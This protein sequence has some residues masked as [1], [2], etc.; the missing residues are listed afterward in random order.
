MQMTLTPELIAEHIDTLRQF[1]AVLTAR[2]AGLSEAEL[3]TETIPGEWTV[4]QIVHHLADSHMNSVIRLKC[5]LTME[6][7]PLI[8]YPQEKWAELADVYDTPI[9]ESLSI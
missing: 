6:Q 5:I 8:G 2:V 3:N 4:R 7:P 1:P 9:E